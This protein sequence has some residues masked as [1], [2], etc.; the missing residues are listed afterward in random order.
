MTP[1]QVAKARSIIS[2]KGY[3]KMRFQVMRQ[4][5][6]WWTEQFYMYGHHEHSFYTPD[7]SWKECQ[8]Y[9]KR[10]EYYK[11]KSGAA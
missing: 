5:E 3:Y 10:A 6:R 1:Q 4:I 8:R 11:L 2:R 9:R 7:V